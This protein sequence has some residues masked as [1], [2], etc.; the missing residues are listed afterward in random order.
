M[1]TITDLVPPPRYQAGD[2]LLFV[3]DSQK[4]QSRENNPRYPRKIPKYTD[5]SQNPK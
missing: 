5:K 4:I 3:A 2:R 1:M